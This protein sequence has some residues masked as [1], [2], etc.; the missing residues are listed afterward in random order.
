MRGNLPLGIRL[1]SSPARPV[2]GYGS[3]G[4]FLDT[5][6]YGKLNSIGDNFTIALVLVYLNTKQNADFIYL[7]F[8]FL[9]Q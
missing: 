8:Y 5:L 3:P 7:I 6:L 9:G 2:S 1:D 4:H